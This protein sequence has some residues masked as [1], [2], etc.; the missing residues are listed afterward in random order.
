M[1][2]R[3]A[4]STLLLLALAT[5]PVQAAERLISVTGRGEVTAPPD[6]AVIRLGVVEEAATAQAAMQA[7][8]DAAAAVLARLRARGI[9]QRDMQTSELRLAPVRASGPQDEGRRITGFTASNA[10]TVRLRDLA[11]LGGALDAVV[12]EGANR[13][14]GL[15]FTV[16]DPAPLMEEARRAAVADA[17]ARAETLAAAAG[18]TL[19]PVRSIA[20]RGGGAPR[21]M[22]M[23][24]ARSGGGGVPVAPG[25]IEITVEVAM[26]LAI[27]AAQ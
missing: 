20:E 23:E 5:A 26:E 10:V 16:A 3:L 27:G 4:A 6:M 9:A 21:P 8:N 7:A 18:V 19:G 24:A 1:P 2:I 25:E 13:L 12:G 11:A 14:D 15:R 22:M 17:M